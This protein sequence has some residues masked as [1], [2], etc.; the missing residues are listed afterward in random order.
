MIALQ[1][2]ERP[3]AVASQQAHDLA[4]PDREV[5]T[6]QDVALAIVGVQIR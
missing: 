6:L 1:V 4:L 2:V 3:D 5:D